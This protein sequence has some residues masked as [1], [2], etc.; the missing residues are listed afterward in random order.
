MMPTPMKVM[1]FVEQYAKERTRYY[2]QFFREL[3]KAECQVSVLNLCSSSLF[4]DDVS[5]HVTQFEEL[6]LRRGYHRSHPS[7]RRFVRAVGPTVIQG[8]ETISTYHAALAVRVPLREPPP[9]VYGRR[10]A[11][12]V[13]WRMRL[14]DLVA[15]TA[16]QSVVAVSEATATIARSE[17][18]LQSRKIVAIH[19]GVELD[20]ASPSAEERTILDELSAGKAS[21]TVLLLSRLRRIKGHDTAIRAASMLAEEIPNLRLLFVGDGPDRDRLE[22]LAREQ[23]LLQRLTMVP[24]MEAV[25]DLMKLADIVIIP[26]YS[27][28]L[29]KVC[30]EAFSAAKPVIA[31]AV[32]GLNDLISHDDTGILIPP[33]DSRA[34]AEAIKRLYTQPDAAK[35]M[36]DRAQSVYQERFT[37]EMMVGKYL[38]LYR[39]LSRSP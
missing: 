19:S 21:L 13:G 26:S 35:S 12:T 15:T 11:H 5:E 28:A 33:R 17:H 3:V 16:C 32:G 37:P 30:I 20:P 31:S 4:R 25:A 34:L 18:P 7:I 22:S 29:P 27:D 8:M 23:G 6:G 36:G 38:A 14:M 24:H 10:H 2:R 9:L 39:N 1:F